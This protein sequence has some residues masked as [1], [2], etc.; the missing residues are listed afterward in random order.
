MKHGMNLYFLLTLLESFDFELL[1]LDAAGWANDIGTQASI[2]Q[3]ERQMRNM[4]RIQGTSH[5]SQLI[6]RLNS[7]CAAAEVRGLN[8][9]RSR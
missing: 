9:W 5:R 2:D 8:R 3:T 1:Q 7:R 4:D 6:D